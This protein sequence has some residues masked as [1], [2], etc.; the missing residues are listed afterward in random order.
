MKL[1]FDENLS[2][3]LVRRLADLFPDSVH[4]RDV[5]LAAIDDL[6]V[7]NH[8]QTGGFVIVSKDDDFHHLSF[9]RGAP[10]KVI[11]ILLGNCTTDAIE[12]LMRRRHADI[13]AFGVDPHAAYLP[14]A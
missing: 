14:L 12:Q 10:P 4:V 11:G 3:D 13:E 5:N 8:G 9:S 7:W 6:G 1:L 2:P